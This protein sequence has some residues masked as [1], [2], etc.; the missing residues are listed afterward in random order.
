MFLARWTRAAA[1]LWRRVPG[2]DSLE[3]AA[4]EGRVLPAAHF[5]LLED[6]A[7]LGAAEL[8]ARCE[9]QLADAAP[10]L[11]PQL[12]LPLSADD[13]EAFTARSRPLQP[14]LITLLRAESQNDE[15]GEILGA[16]GL[17]EPRGMARYN[18]QDGDR[19]FALAPALGK[20]LQMLEARRA[21]RRRLSEVAALYDLSRL[22]EGASDIEQ[23]YK[24]VV[25]QVAKIVTCE[26]I[27]LFLLDKPNKKLEPHAARGRAVNLLEHFAFEK[28]K[29]VSGWVAS[30][31]KP[32]VI[33]DMDKAPNLLNAESLPARV[34]S[35]VAMPMRVQNNVIGVLHV[36]DSEPNAFSP[37]DI[38]LLSLVAGQA[39]VTIERTTAHHQ[40]ETLA[41]T[42]GL[43][44]ALQP[45][46][47]PD[48][49]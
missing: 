11:P 28:G 29:G 32:I 48:A 1:S 14:I 30:R 6:A 10:A 27:A 7:A 9:A 25:A 40:L 35:F 46:L 44:R 26:N 23:V 12:R 36:S 24:A 17:C 19:M 16:V 13:E 38:R 21:D 20:A 47:F 2:G 33:N 42:D 37:D 3:V 15:P 45:P 34:R 41:I 31:G 8:R 39:A 18:A 43:T 22:M 49:P 5:A 4:A